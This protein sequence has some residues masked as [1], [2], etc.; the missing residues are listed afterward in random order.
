MHLLDPMLEHGP[1]D[2]SKNVLAN[3]HDEIGIDTNDMAV[4]RGMMNLAQGEAIA[5]RGQPSFLRIRNDMGGIEQALVAQT[6]DRASASIGLH[7]PSPEL[8]L[9]KSALRRHETR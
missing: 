3:M 8:G 2:L 7:D 6:T 4:K 5:G 1:I 9:M